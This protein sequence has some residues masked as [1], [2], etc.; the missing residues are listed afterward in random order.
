VFFLPP[1][2]RAGKRRTRAATPAGLASGGELAR[3]AADCYTAPLAALAAAGP[4]PAPRPADLLAGGWGH[5][6]NGDAVLPLRWQAIGPAGRLFPA[7]DANLTLAA[8]GPSATVLHLDGVY[9]P[10]PHQPG[11]LASP[12][13]L[14]QVATATA[15]G[16][17]TRTA[18][19]ITAAAGPEQAA[20]CS[21]LAASK[22]PGDMRAA[23]IGSGGPGSYHRRGVTS[24]AA[25]GRPAP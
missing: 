1:A 17:L 2:G 14:C 23:V 16:F 18:A 4:G 12:P 25:Y 10:P 24:A 21:L 20:A 6:A 8:A 13:I 9:R 19:M 11:A 3:A 15:A 5:R 7:L 22:H